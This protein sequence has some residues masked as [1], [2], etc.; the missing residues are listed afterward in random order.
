MIVLYS[1]SSKPLSGRLSFLSQHVAEIKTNVFKEIV[2]PLRRY[3]DHK[4][5]IMRNE[6]V[7][8]NLG[9]RGTAYLCFA[10]IFN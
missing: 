6:H 3:G 2:T 8:N 5:K 4:H 10:K 7:W 1:P 9:N